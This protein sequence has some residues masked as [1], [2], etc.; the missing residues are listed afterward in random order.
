MATLEEIQYRFDKVCFTLLESDI[1]EINKQDPGAGVNNVISKINRHCFG[2]RVYEGKDRYEIEMFY[3]TNF[4]KLKGDIICLP[5]KDPNYFDLLL[6]FCLSL[7]DWYPE[8]DAINCFNTFQ[9]KVRSCL[10]KFGFFTTTTIELEPF[11][12]KNGVMISNSQKG[13][14]NVDMINRTDFYRNFFNKN[15]E[16]KILNDQEYVYLM[17]NDETALIKIGTSKNPRFRE[18][19]LHSSEPRVFLIALWRCKKGFEKE[20]HQKFA[21]KRIR[22]EWFRLSFRDL[23]EIELFMKNY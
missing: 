11:Q 20:L 14:I 12:G 9:T 7:T 3:I 1:L 22:G 10:E 17:V 23:G 13:I 15:F 18:K 21:T 8:L 4:E 6:H 19:T 16:I 2:V 5:L